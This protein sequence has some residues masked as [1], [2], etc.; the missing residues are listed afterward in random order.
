GTGVASITGGF[1]MSAARRSILFGSR[2]PFSRN[3]LDI[4]TPPPKPTTRR[5]N[6]VPTP[7]KNEGALNVMAPL[8]KAVAARP[9]YLHA[10]APT[11]PQAPSKTS[12]GGGTFH[13][14]DAGRDGIEGNERRNP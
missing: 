7:T 2:G 6:T 12:A 1:A 4:R 3:T 10:R 11:A 9:K 8:R 5:P 13:T 14:R